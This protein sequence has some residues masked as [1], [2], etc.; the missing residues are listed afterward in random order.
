MIKKCMNLKVKALT[1][2]PKQ[3]KVVK[4]KQKTVTEKAT[5]SKKVKV[6]VEKNNNEE[7][8]KNND[9]E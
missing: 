8:I 4:P 6:K 2:T 5:I 7:E 1:F 3:D 9:N